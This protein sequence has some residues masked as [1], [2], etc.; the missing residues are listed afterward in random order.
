MRQHE[1]ADQQY[2]LDR[3]LLDEH[4]PSY[5]DTIWLFAS[6]MRA[7]GRISEAQEAMQ[8]GHRMRA[9][10]MSDGALVL[11]YHATSGGP[12]RPAVNAMQA[13]MYR[14]GLHKEK[15]R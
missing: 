6:G 11:A 3:A 9:I 4:S 8:Q 2:K 1:P 12:G 13:E 7:K 14:R 15:P 10:L 5:I